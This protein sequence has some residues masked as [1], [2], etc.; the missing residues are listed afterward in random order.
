MD[1]GD[2]TGFITGMATE[3]VEE[4][5]ILGLIDKVIAFLQTNSIV[6]LIIFAI[7]LFFLYKIVRLAFTI[8][9]VIIAGLLFPF[10][11]NFFFNWGIPINLGTLIFYATFAV[12]LFLLAT[13]IR[14]AGKFISVITSPF[15]KASERKKI[16]E[17]IEEDLEEKRKKE[18][19]KISDMWKKKRK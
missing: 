2:I 12:V 4:F 3:I 1:I 15:R 17:E 10:A 6:T 7:A 19:K 13:F 18:R 8:F 5:S 11:M 9:L 16:E 14:G